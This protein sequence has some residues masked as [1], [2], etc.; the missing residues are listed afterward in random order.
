MV[1]CANFQRKPLVEFIASIGMRNVVV[2]NNG[3]WLSLQFM[4]W[5][6]STIPL[7]L[8][9][10]LC[11]R[12]VINLLPV[13]ASILCHSFLY[14]LSFIGLGKLKVCGKGLVALKPF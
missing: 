2:V 6:L 7:H 8:Y 5:M 14:H 9:W 11:L 13:T 12:F 1:L 10:F 4:A 3:Y